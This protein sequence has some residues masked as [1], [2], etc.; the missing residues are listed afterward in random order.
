MTQDEFKNLERLFHMVSPY[1]KFQYKKYKHDVT[2]WTHTTKTFEALI[3]VVQPTLIIEAG[4]W[5]GKSASVMAKFAKELDHFCGIACVD[6]WLGAREF[7]T[8]QRSVID[9]SWFNDFVSN[10]D[11]HK[12]RYDE[13][14][15]KNGYPSVYYSFLANMM[16]EGIQD[17]VIPFPMPSTMGA[18][19]FKAADVVSEM[20]FID[21]SHEEEDVYNDL[22]AYYKLL[23]PDGVMFGDDIWIDD[24]KKAVDRF[25]LNKYLKPVYTDAYWVVSKNTEVLKQYEELVKT[26]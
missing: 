22:Q 11:F 5:K 21:A 7:F 14:K 15:L 23:A 19:Y 13:L 24:V 9:N 17:M 20:I 6:T 1:E 8:H 10:P 4:S 3:K 2:G 25:C 12:E 16:H 18:R 26:L